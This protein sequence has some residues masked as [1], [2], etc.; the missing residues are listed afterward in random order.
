MTMDPTPATY[1]RD[2]RAGDA[3]AGSTRGEAFRG[4]MQVRTPDG[5]TGQM[6][7]LLNRATLS[8]RS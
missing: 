3:Y 5:E 2:I 4:V 7:E 8:A 6:R 1:I